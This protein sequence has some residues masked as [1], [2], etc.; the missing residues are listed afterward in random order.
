MHVDAG[1]SSRA[2]LKELRFCQ[3]AQGAAKVTVALTVDVAIT[4]GVLKLRAHVVAV[5]DEAPDGVADRH[6]DPTPGV[7]VGVGGRVRRVLVVGVGDQTALTI[8]GEV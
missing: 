7:V 3:A 4:I 2:V 1:G 5:V 6:L 8:V